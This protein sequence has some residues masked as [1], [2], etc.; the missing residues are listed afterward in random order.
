MR[1]RAD[2]DTN[3]PIW[4]SREDMRMPLAFHLTFKKR[5]GYK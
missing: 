2:Y 5:L 3:R 1:C 4:L